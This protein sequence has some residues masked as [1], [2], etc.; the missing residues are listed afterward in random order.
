MF[1][2]VEGKKDAH[3][4]IPVPYSVLFEATADQI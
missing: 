1:L 2:E 4:G 3:A